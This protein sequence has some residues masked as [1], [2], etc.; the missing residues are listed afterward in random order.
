MPADLL[1]QA[2][3]AADEEHRTADELVSEAVRRYLKDR[4]WQR[5]IAYGHER[6]RQLGL[7]E[8]DVP[9][10]IGEYRQEERQGR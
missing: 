4:Q 5:L 10:L 6:A 3:E 8:K 2:R 1:A 7:T 9:R